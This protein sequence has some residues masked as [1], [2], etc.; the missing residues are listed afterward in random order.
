MIPAPEFARRYLEDLL[1]FF[2]LNTKVEDSESE[3]VVELAV[4][5]TRLNGFLIGSGG[6]NLRSLQHL[7]N[8]VVH[9]KGYEGVTVVIDIAGYRKQHQE[10][11]AE[12]AVEL[13]QKAIASGET[14]HLE[15]MS[16]ADRRAAHQALSEIEGITSDSEGEGR[17]RHIV[18]KPQAK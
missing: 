11:V 2:G 3:G 1:S 13:A 15:S 16:P 8:T 5:S 10:K 4:P 18:I 9:A 14:I 7:L 6:Q 17:D 12:R